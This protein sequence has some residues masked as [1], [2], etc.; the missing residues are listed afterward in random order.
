VAELVNFELN[1]GTPVGKKPP[2]STKAVPGKPPLKKKYSNPV[3]KTLVKS[4]TT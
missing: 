3:A 1:S 2:V 4:K